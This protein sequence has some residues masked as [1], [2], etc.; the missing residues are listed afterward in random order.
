MSDNT[1][2]I[3]GMQISSQCSQ[4]MNQLRGDDIPA[5]AQD[6]ARAA[7]AVLESLNHAVE[8]A[9]LRE[10]ISRN[11]KQTKADRAR[12]TELDGGNAT[13]AR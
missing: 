8:R 3:T 7:L 13:E 2:P 12:L 11:E 1:T 10:R 6:A 5:S 9:N 4:I